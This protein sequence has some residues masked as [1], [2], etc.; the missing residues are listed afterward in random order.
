[1]DRLATLDRRLA[2]D[3]QLLVEGLLESVILGTD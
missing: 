1:M 3:E 2:G